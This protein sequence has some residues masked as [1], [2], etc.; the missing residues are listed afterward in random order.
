[1]KSNLHETYATGDREDHNSIGVAITDQPGGYHHFKLT[2]CGETLLLNNTQ[3]LNRLTAM[4]LTPHHSLQVSTDGVVIDGRRI[5]YSDSHAAEDLE[6]LLNHHSE[7]HDF[8]STHS[9]E[10]TPQ[11]H[12]LAPTPSTKATP[13]SADS[14]KV[15]SD[16]FEFHVSYMTKFG[17]RKTEN[18]EAALTAFQNMAVL[19]PH[20]NIQ[21]TGIQLTVTEWDGV[22]FIEAPG[23]DDLART[24]PEQIE[25]I[26]KNNIV[27]DHAASNTKPIV[28]REN[29]SNP[30][31]RVELKKK[32]HDLRFTLLLHRADNSVEEGPLLIRANL[33][34]LHNSGL[35]QAN[36]TISMTAL[37]DALIV[38]RKRG[39]AGQPALDVEKCPI[40]TLDDAKR[41]EVLLNQ[42]LAEPSL[43]AATPPPLTDRA[44]ASNVNQVFAPTME[45]SRTDVLEPTVGHV[46]EVSETNP[47]EPEKPR[48]ADTDLSNPEPELTPVI[49]PQEPQDSLPKDDIGEPNWIDT[50][51]RSSGT[52]LTDEVDPEI[53][54]L[55]QAR[56]QK[57]QHL[58][59]HGFPAISLT[60]RTADGQSVDFE[61]VLLAHYLLCNFSFGYLRF[62]PDTRVCLNP[63]HDFVLFPHNGLRGIITRGH[64]ESVVFIISNACADFLK[65]GNAKDYTKCFE[66]IIATGSQIHPGDDLVW[67]LT[68]EDRLFGQLTDFATDYGLETSD[69]TIALDSSQGKFL[70]FNRAHPHGLEFRSG[71]AY[72]RFTPAGVEI[73]EEQFR[74]TFPHR[75]PLVGWVLDPEGTVCALYEPTE[76]FAPPRECGTVRF[77][78][79][80][81]ME[82]AEESF[83]VM[84]YSK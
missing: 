54:T 24:T 59:E 51:L 17:E 80:S 71:E 50:V 38:Q 43:P 73:E 19:K 26:L 30:V 10:P 29:S 11:G 3:S 55:L 69:N 9:Q 27:G 13:F 53:F 75:I 83:T 7:S 21:K 20:V 63:T 41:A 25:V 56:L 70:G 18:L 4:G 64:G 48:R 6:E 39:T 61:L 35:F 36:V 67:P 65:R 81:D 62:G 46:R 49:V 22:D 16:G 47:P 82:Q 57:K 42:I 72:A 79:A 60:S 28:S 84:A 68:T 12:N 77:V 34:K 14:I 37:N 2:A 5:H 66:E 15:T 23:I 74:F 52:S 33:E 58:N 78:T 31:V 1:M 76:G 32:H 45:M 44:S 40:T 8:H